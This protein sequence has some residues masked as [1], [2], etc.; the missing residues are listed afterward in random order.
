MNSFIYNPFQKQILIIHPDYNMTI[1]FSI[2]FEEIFKENEMEKH[3]DNLVSSCDFNKINH[4]FLY[5]SYH[6]DIKELKK[7]LNKG[8]KNYHF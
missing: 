8:R 1:E 2:T 6:G 7:I 3:Y 4:K 5:Y